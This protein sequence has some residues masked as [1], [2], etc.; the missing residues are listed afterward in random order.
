MSD[1]TY[2]D[3]IDYIDYIDEAM[4]KVGCYIKHQKKDKLTTFEWEEVVRVL[5]LRL[6]QTVKHL[7]AK[8]MLIQD[9][10]RGL[11]QANDIII[12]HWYS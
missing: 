1:K 5:A 12:K 3:Y 7:S 8:T 4:Q 2:C 6:E 10:Q 11:M 9:I